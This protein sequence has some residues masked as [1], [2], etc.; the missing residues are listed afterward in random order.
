MILRLWRFTQV[1]SGSRG[2]LL[3]VFD[4]ENCALAQQLP[5]H[6]TS[7]GQPPHSKGSSDHYRPYASPGHTAI[8]SGLGRLGRGK[9]RTWLGLSGFGLCT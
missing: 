5:R 4:E 8:G 6:R 3:P 2:Q 1:C 7:R 9:S